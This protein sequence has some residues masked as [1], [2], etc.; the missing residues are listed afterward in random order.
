MD[1]VVKIL[2]Y[3]S[4]DDSTIFFG[5]STFSVHLSLT[6]TVFFGECLNLSFSNP[7]FNH[8]MR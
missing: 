1:K 3:K 8:Q 7:Q 6:A 4:L 2:L 5:Q